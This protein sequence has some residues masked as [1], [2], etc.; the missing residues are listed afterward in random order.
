M[1]MSERYRDTSEDYKGYTIADVVAKATKDKEFANKF[2]A[3][4]QRACVSP[5]GEEAWKELMLYFASDSYELAKL[6]LP[7]SEMVGLLWTGRKTGVAGDT[8]T[9]GTTIQLTTLCEPT[10]PPPDGGEEI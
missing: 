10:A 5:V 8:P 6:M 1:I 7:S 2:V 3:I 4:A 9:T